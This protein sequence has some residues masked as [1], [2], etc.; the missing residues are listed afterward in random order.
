[1]RLPLGAPGGLPLDPGRDGVGDPD[2]R[3]PRRL[4]RLPRPDEARR[5]RPARR[6]PA[7]AARR[8]APR[9]PRAPLP[10][11]PPVPQRPHLAPRR[12]DRLGRAVGRRRP[13]PPRHPVGAPRQPGGGVRPA[14]PRAVGRRR[15]VPHRLGLHCTSHHLVH[16]G[17]RARVRGLVPAVEHQGRG[18]AAADGTRAR[19]HRRRDRPRRAHQPR[20][21]L[22]SAAACLLRRVY[23][24]CVAFSAPRPAPPL[25]GAVADAPP[26]RRR[27]QASSS[28]CSP[29]CSATAPSRPS[30]GCAP[31]SSP[32]P[33]RRPRCSGGR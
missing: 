4:L 30:C 13:R 1:M 29:P 19:R 10:A 12:R 27:V 24:L 2:R 3:L 11:R 14:A 15:D 31:W 9:R 8:A 32:Q 26:L 25:P 6:A 22:R 18:C 5:R 17:S 33:R 20:R 21:R 16:G 28:R 23:H 7:R